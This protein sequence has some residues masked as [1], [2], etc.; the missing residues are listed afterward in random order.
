MP[1]PGRQAS[2]MASHENCG[3]KAGWAGCGVP[4]TSLKGYHTPAR[5]QSQTAH[6]RL[7]RGLP[8]SWCVVGL[9]QVDGTPHGLPRARSSCDYLG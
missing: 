1:S 9:R 8:P 6:V 5:G 7:S 4:S 3:G 2:G